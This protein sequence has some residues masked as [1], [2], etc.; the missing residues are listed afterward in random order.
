MRGDY[1]VPNQEPM[2]TEIEDSTVEIALNHQLNV[3]IDAT[4]LNPSVISHWKMVASFNN[5]DIEFKMF[6]ITLVEAI[7]RDALR[8]NPV[9]VKT[10]KNFFYKYI[11]KE[12]NEL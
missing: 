10:I 7:E 11:Y 9:G 6:D 12:K 1:W 8:P 5:A 2:I 3:I 4:N